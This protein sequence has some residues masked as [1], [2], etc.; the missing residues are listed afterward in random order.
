MRGL[1]LTAKEQNRLQVLNRLMGGQIATHEAAAILGV[2][3]RHTWRM[4][5]AYR[6][7]GAAALAH[8]NRNRRPSNA[9]ESETRQLVITL[10]RTRYAGLNHTHLT[11]LLAEREGVSL[12]RPTVRSILLSAGLASPRYRRPPRHRQRRQ[13]MPQE[14]MLLQLDGSYHAW[15]ED[16]GP[17][18]TLLLAVDDATG[19]VPYAVFREREDTHGYFRLLQGIIARHG[20]PLGVY[21]DRHSVFQSPYQRPKDGAVPDDSMPTQWGRALQ[22]LGVTQ[23]F[24]HSPEAKGRVERANGTFQD[25][26]VSEL[27]LVG[28]STLDEANR[29]LSEFLPRY[30]ERFGVPPAQAGIAYRS[31]DADLDIDGVLCHKERRKVARDNTV[32]YHGR[33]LQLFPHVGRTSYVGARVDVQERLDGRVLVA[34]RGKVLTPQEA[35]PLA[36]AL[37]TRKKVPPATAQSEPTPIRNG[38]NGALTAP[39]KPHLLW[40]EDSKLKRRHSELTKAGLKRA[41]RL[42]KRLG[43]PPVTEREGFGQQF[44]EV[45]RRMAAERLTVRQAARALDVSTPTLE[46]LLDQKWVPDKETS[47]A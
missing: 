17:W 39:D 31:P 35:P 13:R 16:R 2:T 19:K 22:E 27:R 9:V 40:Y 33:T 47:I 5:A 4:L 43:R 37:R 25:R 6:K 45:V 42:G 44:E 12:A 3:E 18:L 11:E 20:V 26:L 30:N 8:G 36:A 32:Q 46:K 29:V 23:V 41:R 15:L 7:E 34:Y 21:T 1:T 10:A 38:H 14:G 24:A 28:A